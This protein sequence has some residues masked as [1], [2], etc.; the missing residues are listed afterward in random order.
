MTFVGAVVHPIH[1]WPGPADLHRSLGHMGYWNRGC[2]KTQAALTAH[3]TSF[4]EAFFE[5]RVPGTFGVPRIHPSAIAGLKVLSR[6]KKIQKALG[7]WGIP[8]MNT[9]SKGS[10]HGS[11]ENAASLRHGSIHTA[12]LRFKHFCHFCCWRSLP[13]NTTCCPPSVYTKLKRVVPVRQTKIYTNNQKSNEWLEGYEHLYSK[14]LIVCRGPYAT[15][16]PNQFYRNLILLYS[17]EFL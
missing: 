14:Q 1:F 7:C 13:H 9:S 2:F 4:F 6:L 3:S 8:G 5:G 11:L 17:K 12:V 10:I 16:Y 15:G